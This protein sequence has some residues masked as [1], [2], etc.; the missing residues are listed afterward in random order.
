MEDEEETEDWS[1]AGPSGAAT[2]QAPTD[3]P[4]CGDVSHRCVKSVGVD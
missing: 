1:I 4:E 2:S 3:D